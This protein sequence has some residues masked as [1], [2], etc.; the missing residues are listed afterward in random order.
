[1]PSPDNIRE[2]SEAILK[3]CRNDLGLKG[4]IG[5]YGRSLGGIAT[6]HLAHY[7]DMVIVDRSFCNLYEVAYHKF[8][9]FL[10]VLLFRIGTLGWDSNNDVRFYAL[11]IESD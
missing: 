11:G 10:A 9:G 5:V 4:K 1:M 7:V 6:T 8:Y 3:Y 2:D